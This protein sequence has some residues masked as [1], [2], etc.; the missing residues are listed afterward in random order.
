MQLREARILLAVQL[1]ANQT[2]CIT[3]S[4]AQVSYPSL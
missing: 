2:R 1:L 4:I 3:T